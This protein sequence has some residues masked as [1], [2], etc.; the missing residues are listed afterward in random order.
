MFIADFL[1]E[2]IGPLVKVSGLSNKSRLL[3]K[4]EYKI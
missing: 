3:Q 1:Y 4:C 2:R